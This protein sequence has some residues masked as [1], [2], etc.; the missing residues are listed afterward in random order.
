MQ[1]ILKNKKERKNDRTIRVLGHINRDWINLWNLG[2]GLHAIIQNIRILRPI[3]WRI[4]PN[5]SLPH[6]GNNCKRLKSLSRLSLIKHRRGLGRIFDLYLIQKSQS[7]TPPNRYPYPN[8]TLFP[9][10]EDRRGKQ[11][12]NCPISIHFWK[13]S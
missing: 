10:F 4:L 12:S 11:H 1:N 3:P 5:G 8:H 13:S 2:H 6:S 7:P 9:K